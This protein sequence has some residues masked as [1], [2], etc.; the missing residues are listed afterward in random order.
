MFRGTFEHTIDEKGRVS[1]P[2]RFR[3]YLEEV[4]DRRVVVTNFQIDGLPCLD[5]YPHGAWTRL[6]EQ[7]CSKP[8]FDPR[9]VKFITFYIASA[10]DCEL[11]KQGRILLPATLRDYAGLK[12]DVVFASAITKFRIWDRETWR[13]VHAAAA[14]VANLP[15]VLEQLGV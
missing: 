5:V 10:H 15:E 3:A 4:E 2:A 11:D 14:E 7:L 6:E 1:V 13:K 12:R 8:Q 9:I